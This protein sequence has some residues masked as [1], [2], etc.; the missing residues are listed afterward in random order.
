MP[1][2]LAN[3]KDVTTGVGID[4]ASVLAF[5]V[6]WLPVLQGLIGVSIAI[7]ILLINL[8]RY[9]KIKGFSNE[10]KKEKEEKN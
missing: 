9:K 8:H 7:V 2:K 3:I 5:F 4:L 10:S 1:N 6:T